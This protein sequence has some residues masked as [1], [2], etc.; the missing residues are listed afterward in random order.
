KKKNNWLILSAALSAALSANAKEYVVNLHGDVEQILEVDVIDTTGNP[1]P[2]TSNLQMSI[3]DDN[4]GLDIWMFNN[5]KLRSNVQGVEFEVTRYVSP[6]DVPAGTAPYDFYSFL[7]VNQNASCDE[8]VTE[9]FRRSNGSL[10][11]SLPPSTLSAGG[12]LC[13]TNVAYRYRDFNKQPFGRYSSVFKL[14]INPKL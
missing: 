6:L 1:Y 13:P 7:D 12:T 14:G 9:T 2:L 8:K 4:K 11:M 10:P 3:D 5:Y